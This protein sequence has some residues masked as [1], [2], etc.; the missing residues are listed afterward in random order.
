MTEKTVA[1]IHFNTPE[2]TEA[3]IKSIRKHGGEKYRVVVF[4]NSDTRPFN[5]RM[6]GVKVIDNTQGQIIDFNKELEAYPERD[7]SIGCAKGCEFGSAKHMMTVQKLWELLPDGFVLMESDIL[8]KRDIDEFF[9]PQYSVYGYWQKS[10]PNNPFY[11]GRMLPMLCWINVPMLTREGAKYFDPERTYGLLPGGRNNRNN[12]YDTGSVLLED[13]LNHRPNLKG[14]HRDIR[15]FVEHYGSGS[16]ANNDLWQQSAWLDKHRDLWQTDE[17]TT[18]AI[19]AIGR[20]ENRY[21]VE[22]VEHYKQLGVAHIYIYDNNREGEEHFE[23]V[24][25]PYIDEGLVEI[26]PWTGIQ[27]QAY[28]DC[29]NRHQA[30]HRWIGFFDFDELVEISGG[31]SVHDLL[32]GFEFADVLVMNWRTMTDNGLLHYEPKPMKERFTEAT[33][34]DFAINRH[35]KSFVQTGIEGISFNDPHCPNAPKLMV[36]NVHGTRVNQVPIQAQVIHD[37][38]RVDHYNTKSTEE[39]IDVKWKRGT[40]CGDEWTEM[41]R[42]DCVEYYFGINKRTKEKEAILAPLMVSKPKTTKSTNKKGKKI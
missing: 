38:A 32:E 27:K 9:A 3:G 12:W 31:R 41:K 4:D 14:Y 42:K 10:Q 1:I 17:T 6:R 21:A 34:E 8:L 7:R 16:W 19:C 39:Y 24:L 20:L 13:I 30:E 11:I 33:G 37:V 40:C 2:L 36:V 18:V 5:R 23:D 15:E 35:V 26:T 28:E 22:W 25:Q 29:Y